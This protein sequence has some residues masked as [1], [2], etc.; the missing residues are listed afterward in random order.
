MDGPSGVMPFRKFFAGGLVSDAGD[1]I[2]S[3]GLK[4]RLAQLIREEDT[5]K[6]LTDQDLV[7]LLAA[8]GFKLARRTVAKYREEL[9]LP[10][11]HLRRHF[12]IA[13]R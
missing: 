9:N 10:P 4:E 7:K 11:S 5:A 3:Q 2:S 13:P 8:Q 6:P 12:T 1:K